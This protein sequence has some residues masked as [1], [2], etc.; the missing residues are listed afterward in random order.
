MSIDVTYERLPNFYYGCGFLGHI[1]RDCLV[2][3]DEERE[4]EKQWGSWLRASPRRGRIRMEE[5]VKSFQSCARNFQFTP[6][7]SSPG[8]E[9][10]KE[11]SAK[12]HTTNVEEESRPIGGE[13]NDENAFLDSGKSTLEDPMVIM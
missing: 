5:E 6:P 13:N 2:L 9:S 12:P 11:L 1:E 10:S 4:H 8:V 7:T 3:T